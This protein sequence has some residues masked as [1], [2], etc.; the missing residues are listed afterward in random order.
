[1]CGS[2][3]PGRLVGTR[4]LVLAGGPASLGAAEEKRRW[5]GADVSD[6]CGNS[7]EDQGLSWSPEPIE[8]A[9]RGTPRL[10]GVG[11]SPE[12]EALLRWRPTDPLAQLLGKGKGLGQEAFP[13]GVGWGAALRIPVHTLQRLANTCKE[14]DSN[15]GARCGS[16]VYMKDSDNPRKH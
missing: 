8:P 5:C 1:M 3:K 11:R 9:V 2:G 13:L 7:W 4:G 16:L 6:G 15:L 14:A 10:H 12:A